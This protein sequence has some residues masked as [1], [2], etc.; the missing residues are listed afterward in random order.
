MKQQLTVTL[1]QSL[2]QM[3]V[4]IATACA[5]AIGSNHLR[6]GGIALVGDWSAQARFADAAGQPLVI[7]L[8]QASQLFEEGGAIFVDARSES[9]YAHGHIRGALNLP[10][11]E[12]DRDFIEVTGQLEGQKTIVTYCDGETCDLSH[13][14]ALFL[15][16]MGFDNV[17][18]LVNGWTMWQQ[19]GLP[20]QMGE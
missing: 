7:E 1:K 5:I 14:L 9:Q 13:E 2:W 3:A 19:A 11:Q 6:T 4:L 17:R 12:V 16:E 8:A 15:K 20:T 18:V 10:W